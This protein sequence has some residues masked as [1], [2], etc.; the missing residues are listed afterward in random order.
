RG[1]AGGNRA[2][3][4]VCFSRK[5]GKRIQEGVE[6]KWR[7]EGGLY[8]NK[9]VEGCKAKG[10]IFTITAD[11]T[12]PLLAAITALPEQRWRPLPEYALAEV[13]ELRYQPTGWSHLYRYVIK[14]EIAETKTGEL[15]WKYHATVTNVEEQ[16][17]RAIV[18]WNLQHAAME[19]AIK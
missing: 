18:V 4:V 3:I 12:E 17:P 11:Q 2:R 19:N 13:A 14:R 6:K 1:G 8:S 5:T 7:G 9:V 10:F 15:Y 16:S